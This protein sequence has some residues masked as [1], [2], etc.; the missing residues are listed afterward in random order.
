MPNVNTRRMPYQLYQTIKYFTDIDECSISLH[1]CHKNADCMNLPGIY[2]CR[3]HTGF[4]GDG[5]ICEHK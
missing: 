2:G 4:I 1:S 5:N 3:C